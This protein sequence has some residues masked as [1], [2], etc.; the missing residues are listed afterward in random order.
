MEGKRDAAVDCRLVACTLANRTAADDLAPH[1]QIRRHTRR[2]S[3]LDPSPLERP[4]P[5]PVD[6]PERTLFGTELSSTGLGDPAT[7]G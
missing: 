1:A 3:R 2:T 6:D 7:C 5:M 4:R